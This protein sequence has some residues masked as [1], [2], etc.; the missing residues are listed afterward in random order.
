MIKVFLEKL[1]KVTQ[2]LL[3]C[4]LLLFSPHH[5]SFSKEIESNICNVPKI[6]KKI[7]A[8]IDIS[9]KLQNTKNR[10]RWIA[11][12]RVITQ[13]D[14][15]YA[16]NCIS[17]NML[18]VYKKS[19][20]DVVLNY[21]KWLKVNKISFYAPA[22]NFGW[23]NVFVNKI[24]EKYKLKKYISDFEKGSIIAKES[25]VFDLQGNILVGPLFYMVKMKKGFNEIS[26]DWKFVEVG[27][28]GSLI[29]TIRSN[30]DLTRRCIQCHSTQ[31]SKDFLYFI[32]NQ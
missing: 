20:S 29:E 32:K 13:S 2:Y 26:N 11:L 21:R 25:F 4:Y 18:S 23:G 31:R 6:P 9:P 3:L 17:E 16:Y 22:N 24:A 14:L 28:D 30:K 27:L 15:I 8:L 7:Q 5:E 12:D 19:N 1:L 10:G